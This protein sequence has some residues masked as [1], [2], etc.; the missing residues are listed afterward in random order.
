MISHIKQIFIILWMFFW[1]IQKI[2]QQN[3]LPIWKNALL[4][5]Y[6]SL[7]IGKKCK[8]AEITDFD[9]LSLKNYLKK[10]LKKFGGTHGIIIKRLRS[11]KK[12]KICWLV[13]LT[14]NRPYIHI[15]GFARQLS[16]RAAREPQIV[17]YLTHVYDTKKY[18][19]KLVDKRFRRIFSS[20]F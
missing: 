14:K 18:F 16:Q 1:K 4:M 10:N 17:L 2:S 8:Y 9:P 3:I 13:D 15:W 5:S 11:L 19:K 20:A 7:K 6:K 12:K